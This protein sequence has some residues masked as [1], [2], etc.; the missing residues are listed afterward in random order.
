MLPPIWLIVYWLTPALVGVGVAVL[1][2]VAVAVAAAVGVGVG[3]VVLVA[4]AV[5]LDVGVTVGV[6]QGPLISHLPA[7]TVTVAH[8]PPSM[9]SEPTCA[10]MPTV[11]CKPT[12][13]N[14]TS[15]SPSVFAATCVAAGF[16]V[17]MLPKLLLRVVTPA[18]KGRAAL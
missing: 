1:A 2:A 11:V 8:Y 15:D 9:A 17:T 13:R 10:V 3:V 14:A 7:F 4:V 6:R 12:G 5:G 16:G 18:I